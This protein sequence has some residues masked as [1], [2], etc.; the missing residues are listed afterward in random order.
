MLNQVKNYICVPVSNQ[1]EYVLV[2]AK[3]CGKLASVFKHMY[4]VLSAP[5]AIV[6]LVG[7][8]TAIQVPIFSFALLG[9]HPDSPNLTYVVLAI[10]VEFHHVVLLILVS[11]AS[12]AKVISAELEL[13]R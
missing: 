10:S 12:I 2:P 5:F 8:D 3:A 7:V 6:T 1:V 9:A 4:I 11:C 13:R